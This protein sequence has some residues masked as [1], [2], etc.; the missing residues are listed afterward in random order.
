VGSITAIFP[1]HREVA[2]GG[3]T[4]RVD[5]LRLADLA[6]LQD[7]LDRTWVDPLA[8]LRER[9]ATMGDAERQK[10]LAP[11]YDL[12]EAGPPT[13][14]DEQGRALFATGA[15]I[16]EIF[17][18][19]LRRHHPEL[20]AGD[21]ATIAER[22]TPAEYAAL[23]RV[24]Y[25]VEPMDEIEA[26]L[27]SDEGPPGSPIDWPKAAAEVA[28]R[29]GWSL[30]YIEGLTLRQFRAAR[31]GGRPRVRGTSVA[32]RTNLKAVVAAARRKWSGDTKGVD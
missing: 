30:E 25:G 22:T 23:R 6:D 21:V 8:G 32:P 14:G 3:R 16:V 15:G 12:A 24:L 29:Y 28:E 9:L 4:F 31:S 7:W 27:R 13:C 1:R 17:R 19:A 5:E 20:D 26:W 11:A 18:V 10:A 2:L